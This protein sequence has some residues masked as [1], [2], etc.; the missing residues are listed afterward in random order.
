MRSKTTLRVNGDLEFKT[1]K[2]KI[3]D[4]IAS[5]GK[6][7]KFP[8]GDCLYLGYSKGIPRYYFF[9]IAIKGNDKFLRLGE[10][11][12][13]SFEAARSDADKY[14]AQLL[15]DRKIVSTSSY[16][17][18]I[19]KLTISKNKLN[20]KNF[21]FENFRDFGKFLDNL[22]LANS[23]NH[24]SIISEL[25]MAIWL[26]LLIPFNSFDIIYAQ[27]GDF[28]SHNKTW[29]KMSKNRQFIEA[30]PLGS[31]A[32]NVINDY[33]CMLAS[34]FVQYGKIPFSDFN[35]RPLFQN[36]SRKSLVDVKFIIQ[37]EICS[38]KMG[39]LD[40]SRLRSFF[41]YISIEFGLY[42]DKFIRKVMSKNSLVWGVN[43]QNFPA[44]YAAL[45]DWW[46]TELN[47]SL[48]LFSSQP[49]AYLKS[50]VLQRYK[51]Q[52]PLPYHEYIYSTQVQAASWTSQ[53]NEL[54]TVD[55]VALS[56][57]PQPVESISLGSVN[58]SSDFQLVKDYLR[59]RALRE[60][61]EEIQLE[62]R[63]VSSTQIL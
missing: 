9:R 16:D 34:G 61:G 55:K 59:D 40:F 51:V 6:T 30:M 58:E 4:L 39:G 12:L 5:D 25:Q 38:I 20:F 14:L 19:S 15:S 33:K 31:V 57:L 53:K 17:E 18:K 45:M 56:Q 32:F 35:T 44:Q 8:L 62:G 7:K 49:N 10:F 1:I 42:S 21:P 27:I 50:P 46:G 11:N 26:L 2:L 60:L 24:N 36:L 13:I 47:Q 43:S 29:N 54:T 37:Q 52:F 3:F 48:N 22:L 28:Y 63:H 23:G 41:E